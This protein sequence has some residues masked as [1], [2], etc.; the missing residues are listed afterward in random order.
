MGLL[1]DSKIV[2][3]ISSNLKD[4]AYSGY[5]QGDSGYDSVVFPVNTTTDVQYILLSTNSKNNQAFESG[6]LENWHPV[7][8]QRLNISI[9]EG[10]HLVDWHGSQ[11]LNW[12]GCG[13]ARSDDGGESWATISSGNYLDPHPQSS[14]CSESQ[15]FRGKR[16]FDIGIM[17][18]GQITIQN[19]RAF[20][21]YFVEFPLNATYCKERGLQTTSQYDTWGAMGSGCDRSVLQLAEVKYAPNASGKATGED[22]TTNKQGAK[23]DIDTTTSKISAASAGGRLTVNRDMP[24]VNFTMPPAPDRSTSTQSSPTVWHVSKGDAMVIALAEVNRWIPTALYNQGICAAAN[25]TAAPGQPT[26][27]PHAPRPAPGSCEMPGCAK[28]ILVQNYRIAAGFYVAH[29]KPSADECVSEC[30]TNTSCTGVT[31]KAANATGLAACG[32]LGSTCCYFMSFTSVEQSNYFGEAYQW[33][34]WS[35]VGLLNPAGVPPKPPMLANP[36]RLWRNPDTAGLY[37]RSASSEG[38]GPQLV[39]L[40]DFYHADE[41]T[42]A[43]LQVAFRVHGSGT[44]LEMR[45]GGVELQPIM[46]FHRPL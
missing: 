11:W 38:E 44:I 37:F 18:Q 29:S 6:D 19:K 16:E 31:F 1:G 17:H 39:W 5:V 41:T 4:W 9:G 7:F 46:Q 8:G 2:H 14:W 30:S 12:E 35:S 34:S 20:Y 43:L 26:C 33:S 24:L 10:P 25:V 28:G 13:L 32:G 45:R 40:L 21:L 3:Y 36:Q 15:L 42:G 27:G 22:A 23:A